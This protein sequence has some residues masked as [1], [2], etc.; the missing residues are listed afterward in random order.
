M[1]VIIARPNASPL[2]GYPT[3]G[4]AQKRSTGF[5]HT[6]SPVLVGT[7]HGAIGPGVAIHKGKSLTSIYQRRKIH[8]ENL[9]V[10][11]FKGKIHVENLIVEVLTYIPHDKCTT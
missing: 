3:A 2:Q 5:D 1:Y 7:G 10:E 4:R 11:V 8:V 9:T 6:R